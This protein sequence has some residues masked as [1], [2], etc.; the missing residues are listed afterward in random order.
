MVN[1]PC[2]IVMFDHRRLMDIVKQQ[3]YHQ[4]FGN[5][6]CANFQL[7]GLHPKSHSAEGKIYPDT[8]CPKTWGFNGFVRFFPSCYGIGKKIGYLHHMAWNSILPMKYENQ[9]CQKLGSHQIS[10]F[11]LVKSYQIHWF[12]FL[13]PKLRCWNSHFWSMNRGTSLV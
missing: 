10:P 6:S 2:S 11:Q 9:N 8:H 7:P 4:P 1:G 13:N 5:N 3:Q 12:S